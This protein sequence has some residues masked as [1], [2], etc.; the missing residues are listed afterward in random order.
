MANIEQLLEHKEQIP[1]KW[2][3]LTLEQQQ[4]LKRKMGETALKLLGVS[5]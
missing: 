5:V 2:N 4:E 1:S 3:Q